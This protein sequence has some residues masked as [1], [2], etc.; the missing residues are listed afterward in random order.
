MTEQIKLTP[1]RFDGKL[2]TALATALSDEK[3]EYGERFTEGQVRMAVWRTLKDRIETLIENPFDLTQ[4]PRFSDFLGAPR[5]FDDPRAARCA[6]CGHP[7]SDHLEGAPCTY[8]PKSC[9]CAA[10]VETKRDQITFTNADPRVYDGLGEI[11]WVAEKLCTACGHGKFYIQTSWYDGCLR[12]Q[13]RCLRCDTFLLGLPVDP[14][15]RR[16]V[17]EQREPQEE[18]PN[19][20]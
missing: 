10:F 5:P 2:I 4:E 11:R 18:G 9:S 15:A 3:C 19:T 7:R 12:E 6:N 17:L 8:L 14:D 1:D 13:P 16:I 20:P